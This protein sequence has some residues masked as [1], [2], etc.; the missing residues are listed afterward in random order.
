MVDDTI[1]EV[2]KWMTE[3]FYIEESLTRVNEKVS[4]F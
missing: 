2:L 1:W 4:L 3:A